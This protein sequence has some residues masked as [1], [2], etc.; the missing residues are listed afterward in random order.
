MT[1]TENIVKLAQMIHR[2]IIVFIHHIYYN[3]FIQNGGKHDN[4][5]NVSHV[6]NTENIV[7]LAQMIHRYISFH[8][9]HLLQHIYSEWWE[10]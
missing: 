2:Y 9:S 7:K 5:Y 1:N 10:T 6:T 8:T 4:N 3:T